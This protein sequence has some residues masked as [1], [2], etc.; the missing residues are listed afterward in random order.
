MKKKRSWKQVLSL[1]ALFIFSGILGF[2]LLELFYAIPN[3][4]FWDF[5]FSFFIL[6][7]SFPLHIVLHEIGHLVAGLFSG[8]QFIMFR[9]FNW[10]WIKTEN[11]VSKRK[12]SIQGL[13]G[14]ALMTPPENVV[15]PPMLLYHSGGLIV[16]FI[17]A[18]LLLVAGLKSSNPRVTLF[19]FLSGLVAFL[20]FILNIVPQKGTDGYNIL[21]I[22]KRPEVLVETT[23]ILRLYGGMVRGESFVDL[24][25]YMPK[26]LPVSFE[27]PNKVTFYTALAA[28]YFEDGN[29]ETASKMYRQ[30]WLKRKQ[31]IPLH[32]PE[33]YITYL[34]S[35]YLTDPLHP[36]VRVIQKSQ[37]YK[38]SIENKAADVYKVQ[39]AEAIYLEKDYKKAR[40]LLD[41]GEELIST[42]PTVSEEHLEK[43]FYMYLRSE[44]SHLE[45]N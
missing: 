7:I 11:G 35:L 1:I 26:D 44:I 12:Q 25:R 41:E 42:A 39:A 36:D 2:S 32:K 13:L 5:I 34:F 9:L 16:N 24:K 45:N 33:V 29:F 38:N 14:Q 43:L 8:Y 4:S 31:L 37:V 15:E 20:L 28:A 27:D 17:S 23:N 22:R 21:Q 6:V 18:L 30:L 19:L 40:G 3:L 10:V